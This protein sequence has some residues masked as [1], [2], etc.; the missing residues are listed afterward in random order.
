MEISGYVFNINDVNSIITNLLDRLNIDGLIVI[1]GEDTLSNAFL[2]QD[3]PIVLISK[4]I[5]NDVGRFD[6]NK[7]LNYFRFNN[8]PVT[9]IKVTGTK[10]NDTTEQFDFNVPYQAT[11]QFFGILIAWCTRS[12]LGNPLRAIGFLLNYDNII[13]AVKTKQGLKETIEVDPGYGKYHLDGHRACKVCMEPRDSIKAHNI[14]PVCKRPLTIGVL[15]R[16]E[17]LADRPEGFMP[18]ET[19]PFRRII[20][21]SEIIASILGT[22]VVASK[23]VWSEHK[24]LIEAFGSEYRVLLEAPQKEMARIIDPRIAE[25]IIRVRE[26]RVRIQP[27][28]DG[29]YGKPLFK[30]E[31]VKSGVMESNTQG[32][33]KSIMDF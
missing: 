7:I 23:R 2:F 10:V 18:N 27:G 8:V 14:C 22:G 28:F 33:Q 25:A 21:L 29:E 24:K 26:G 5:D 20:P 6:D 3:F 12:G 19:K 4:T 16:I 1:G 31:V 30:G 32:K 17:E 13:N 11:P 15:H 9:A